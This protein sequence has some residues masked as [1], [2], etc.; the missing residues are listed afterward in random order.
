MEG[1]FERTLAQMQREGL[2]DDVGVPDP[3]PLPPPDIPAD[4]THVQ[5]RVTAGCSFPFTV[6][7][8]D[9]AMQ[10]QRNEPTVVPIAIYNAL[11]NSDYTFEARPV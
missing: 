5:V 2:L 8:G 11:R 9:A 3:K 6:R 1:L 4:A 7:N 10:L